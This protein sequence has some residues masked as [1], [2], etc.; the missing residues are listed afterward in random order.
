MIERITLILYI[1]WRALLV[2]LAFV[3]W[4]IG[5]LIGTVAGGVWSGLKQ[6][7]TG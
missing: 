7:F 3:G 2:T 5:K 4:I 6:G 1:V